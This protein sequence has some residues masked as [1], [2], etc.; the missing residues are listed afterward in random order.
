MSFLK[1]LS[2]ILC[3]CCFGMVSVQAETLEEAI[4]KTQRTHPSVEAAQAA[5]DNA[6]QQRREERSGFFPEISVNL[7]FGR[8]FG[9]NSTTR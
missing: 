9:D 7:A 8:I 1:F 4:I 3:L 2:L 5:L 6:A